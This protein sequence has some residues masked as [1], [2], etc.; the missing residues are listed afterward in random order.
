[1][2]NGQQLI[3]RVV[4]DSEPCPDCRYRARIIRQMAELP[5]KGLVGRVLGQ[6][7]AGAVVE[8]RAKMKEIFV[9]CLYCL[10]RE[11][12]GWEGETW[13]KFE[14][15]RTIQNPDLVVHNGGWFDGA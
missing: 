14:E 10:L 7:D 4:V 13:M 1:M 12:W 6:L 8:S 15:L 5:P 11:R 9:L 3:E 2:M